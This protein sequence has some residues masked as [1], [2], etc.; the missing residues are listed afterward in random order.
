MNKFSPDSSRSALELSLN[1]PSIYH[2]LDGVEISPARMPGVAHYE[3]GNGRIAPELFFNGSICRTS[4]GKMIFAF[5]ADQKPWWKSIRVGI[6][7]LNDKLQ[8]LAGTEQYLALKADN[9]FHV[10]DPRLISVGD[11][12][13]VSYT[14]GK[15]MYHSE[16][17]QDTLMV[18]ENFGKITS[19]HVT[20]ASP[21]RRDKN[22]VPFE[23]NGRVLY[24]YSDAPRVII[25]T[26]GVN[27]VYIPGQSA[28]W[29]FGHV[30]GGTPAVK[31]GNDFVSFFHSSYIVNQV[32][33]L[34]GQ[35]VYYMGAYTFSCTPPFSLKKITRVPLMKGVQSRENTERPTYSFVVFPAGVVQEADHFIVSYGVN[36]LTT[37]AIRIS[38]TT[39][40]LLLE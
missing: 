31:W 34:I 13:F 6:C 1:S 18:K 14:D 28:E 20:S 19:F 40:N 15:E 22:F 9:P 36:D 23:Y 21:E 17:C 35:R 26:N 8:P 11:R 32:N 30:R 16:I 4:N 10:E 27:D 7:E 39:L 3:T 2:P 29:E 33:S 25:E 38:K 37:R 5:R 12:V 24:S